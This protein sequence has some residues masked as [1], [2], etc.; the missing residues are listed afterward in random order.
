VSGL[1]SGTMVVAEGGEGS[2]VIANI[3]R[4]SRLRPI[5]HVAIPK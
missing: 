2:S 4:S 5:D 1:R 3:Q